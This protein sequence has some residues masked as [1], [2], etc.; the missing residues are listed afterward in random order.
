VPG[1]AGSVTVDGLA[2]YENVHLIRAWQTGAGVC[3]PEAGGLCLGLTTGMAYLGTVTADADG[4]AVYDMDVPA[5]APVGATVAFQ[6][7]AVRGFDGATSI[8]SEAVATELQPDDVDGDGFL[9]VDDCNDR[10]PEIY[11]GAVE[12]C[13]GID[14][15]CDGAIEPDGL[16]MVE[17]LY[18]YPT[19]EA[20]I[21]VTQ[22]G[23]LIE[24]CAG[25][26]TENDLVVPRRMTIR[27]R[28]P[29]LT[30]LDGQ[31]QGGL[32]I[33]EAS[34]AR[35][36]GM[37]LTR[38]VGSASSRYGG[39]LSTYCLSTPC[40]SLSGIVF[41]DLEI[42]ANE[43]GAP[44]YIG[45]RTSAS[46]RNSHVHHND[47]GGSVF[48]VGG[49]LSFTDTV[50]ADNQMNNGSAIEVFD[51]VNASRLSV[52]RNSTFGSAGAF[53]LSVGANLTCTDCDLG[54][55]PDDNVPNDMSLR[56]YPSDT[57]HNGYGPGE[58]FSCSVDDD[59]SRPYSRCTR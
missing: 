13:D 32:F 23:G 5:T 53:R 43:T 12:R 22:D 25:T 26:Y 20:A 56:D 58:T 17:G 27:G 55:G 57:I 6:A 10:D 28:G 33:I 16:V 31:D 54:L 19:I 7:V 44:V 35:I 41:D 8:A 18:P 59:Y 9:G 15:D 42:T 38:G 51:R 21:Q 30:I 40:G 1:Y 52:L 45:A 4:V 36:Q 50:V 39:A 37:T 3:V 34:G 2:A 29:G 46:M 47:I 49:A 11:P 14:N 24:L 48:S